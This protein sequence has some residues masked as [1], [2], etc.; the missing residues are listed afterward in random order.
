MRRVGPAWR[1][2]LG[3]PFALVAAGAGQAEPVAPPGLAARSDVAAS[4]DMRRL[5]HW[6]VRSNDAHGRPFIIVDKVAAR[7]FAFRSDGSLRGEAP[8]LL[9]LTRGDISPPGI[10]DRKL[11]DIGPADRITPAGRFEAEMGR[12]LT[13]DVLWVDYD[14]AISLHRVVTNKPAERRLA[15]LATASASD[16]RISYGCINVPAAFYEA[17]VAPLF[18]PE[19]G[20]VYVLPER[21]AFADV[22][23]AAAS[24]DSP[25]SSWHIGAKPVSGPPRHSLPAR[26][27]I[28]APKSGGL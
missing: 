17:I 25:P 10:G 15:R 6:V 22:F 23:A 3:L 7:V 2:T 13:H 24:S 11:A 4:S 18:R 19:N 16:N 28:T 26:A 14:A 12:D 27:D 21:R 5:A 1:V 20:V 8:A 9:G